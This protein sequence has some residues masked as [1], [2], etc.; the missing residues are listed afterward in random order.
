[1]RENERF[2]EVRARGAGIRKSPFGHAG[3]EA[4]AVTRRRAGVAGVACRS[5]PLTG[6]G[7]ANTMMLRLL[8]VIGAIFAALA[9]AGTAEAALIWQSPESL[10]SAPNSL[11]LGPDGTGLL[12][13]AGSGGAYNLAV[14]P[15]G[16]PVGGAQPLPSPLG[17]QGG[18]PLIGWFPD[19]SSLIADPN[20][21]RVAFRPAGAA[22]AIGMPQDLSP[23]FRGRSPPCLRAR[24]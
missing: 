17:T 2:N 14:R 4:D 1:M 8:K 18:A 23:T 11:A 9:F 10:A 6:H 24:H 21:R 16:G 3:P 7:G 12:T 19:G 20:T 13:F 15:A 22:A 5:V